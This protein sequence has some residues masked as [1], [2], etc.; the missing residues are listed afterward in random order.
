VST[1]VPEDYHGEFHSVASGSVLFPCQGYS[2][3]KPFTATPVTINVR[4][5]PDP[6][7]YPAKADVVLSLTQK[8]FLD[9]KI[10]ELN[11]LSGQIDTRAERSGNDSV[12][13]RA[14]L[15]GI[16]EKAEVDLQ[17]RLAGTPAQA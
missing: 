10:A 12:E 13:L 4:G 14:F 2:V 7:N 17:A 1:V 11:D 16:V 5:I 6:N 3:Q 15:A 9:T 8:Q